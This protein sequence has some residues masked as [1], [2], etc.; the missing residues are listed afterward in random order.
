M[1]NTLHAVFPFLFW[2]ILLHAKYCYH[3]WHY[4]PMQPCTAANGQGGDYK[5]HAPC[6]GIGGCFCRDFP[7]SGN[8]YFA[9]AA[10]SYY[11]KK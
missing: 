8:T 1:P 6:G 9:Q 5:K 4:M 10:A 3:I 7:D 11:C 2:I